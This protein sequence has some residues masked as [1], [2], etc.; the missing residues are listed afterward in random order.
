MILLP[1]SVVAEERAV[2]RMY[3]CLEQ[4]I[5]GNRQFVRC[6]NEVETEGERRFDNA[7]ALDDLATDMNVRS[8]ALVQRIKGVLSSRKSK[9][10][11]K[12]FQSGG[13]DFYQTCIL[14]HSRQNT[15]KNLTLARCSYDA[16]LWT[17]HFLFDNYRRVWDATKGK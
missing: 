4:P 15:E 10:F 9:R 2:T 1:V 11:D 14:F 13:W 7:G 8:K 6:L 12:R 17:L 16:E 3:A 5:S